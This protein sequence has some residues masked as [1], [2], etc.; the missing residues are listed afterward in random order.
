MEEGPERES[1]RTSKQTQFDDALKETLA[2]EGKD[3]RT[4]AESLAES[5]F[6][7][8]RNGNGRMAQLVA[9]RTGGKPSQ[10]LRIEG[11]FDAKVSL[12]E[13]DSKIAELL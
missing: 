12:G 3:G 6:T 7:H 5:V 13:L 1:I 10:H 2:T 11:S 8:A 4:G 9:E